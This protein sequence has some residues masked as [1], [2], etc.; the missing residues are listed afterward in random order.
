MR[1]HSGGH[2]GHRILAIGRWLGDHILGTLVGLGVA[3]AVGAG[4]AA[5]WPAG[6]SASVPL[7]SQWDKERIR[8]AEE[9]W[10]I[11]TDRQAELTGDT[12]P[13]TVIGLH[14][15][16]ERC[17]YAHGR[18][19]ELRIYGTSGGHLHRLFSFEPTARG[20]HSWVFRLGPI[21]DLT[22]SGRLWAFGSFFG[23]SLSGVSVPVAIAWNA[24]HRRFKLTPLITEVPEKLIEAKRAEGQHEAVAKEMQRIILKPVRLTQT[25]QPAYV[26]SDFKVVPRP[27]EDTYLFALYMLTSGVAA[28]NKEG[29]TATAPVIYQRA[30][31]HI[32]IEGEGIDAGWCG[33]TKQQMLAN[34]PPESGPEDLLESFAE[35]GRHWVS[36]C[37]APLLSKWWEA[38]H[39]EAW[40]TQ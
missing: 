39:P 10:E 13:V 29:P 6:G 18:S 17:S 7:T 8:I 5:L 33:L 21:A 28:A 11:T 35:V 2:V 30:L 20:C 4:I 3:A 22:G 37:N 25:T 38:H 14:Q 40:S 15:D 27:E 36:S 26:V 12:S 1:G 23:G 31:W 16:R 34:T 24:A 32:D 19:D 9:G